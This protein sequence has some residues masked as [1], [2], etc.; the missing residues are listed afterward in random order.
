MLL[1]TFLTKC[2]FD[3]KKSMWFT[4]W[5]ND[6][7]KWLNNIGFDINSIFK[8][9]PYEFDRM[10]VKNEVISSELDLIIC[11]TTN[12]NY[13]DNIIGGSVQDIVVSTWSKGF[14]YNCKWIKINKIDRENLRITYKILD[15]ENIEQIKFSEDI[16]ISN[17]NVFLF[18][19][20]PKKFPTLLRDSKI[21]DILN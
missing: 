16:V 14:Y 7:I 19:L 8:N 21:E 10:I 6:L 20:F 13:G 11:W 17:L 1:P 18:S 12:L 3:M 15:E 4:I 9:R 2:Y 5:E